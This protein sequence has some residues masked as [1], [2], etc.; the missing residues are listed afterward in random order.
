[1]KI[2]KKMIYNLLN[3]QLKINWYTFSAEEYDNF[4]K[5]ER[6]NNPVY[7]KWEEERKIFKKEVEKSYRRVFN[8]IEKKDWLEFDMWVALLM[9][10]LC[11]NYK[12][13]EEEK[14]D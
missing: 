8:K 1:M 5:E 14:E 10:R 2:T 13:N 11:F 9:Q 12:N 3:K 6:D 4:T 7:L